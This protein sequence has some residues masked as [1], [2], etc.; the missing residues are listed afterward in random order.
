LSATVVDGAAF[1]AIVIVFLRMRAA[2]RS[3]HQHCGGQR[4][5]SDIMTH[6]LLPIPMWSRI[7]QLFPALANRIAQV[8]CLLDKML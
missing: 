3:Q 2:G 6:C 7:L 5:Q 4:Y 1:A 8:L